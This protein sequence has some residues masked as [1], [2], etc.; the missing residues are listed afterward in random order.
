MLAAQRVDLA[1]PLVII[2]PLI[3]PVN[4]TREL[5]CTLHFIAFTELSRGSFVNALTHNELYV[6]HI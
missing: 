2:K 3:N 5:S 6:T 4:L 1:K